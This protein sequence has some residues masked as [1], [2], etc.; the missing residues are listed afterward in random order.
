MSTPELTSGRD[1]TRSR[2]PG[3][4]GLRP[5]GG[6]V[7]TAGT[8]THA[9]T[10]RERNFGGSALR[11]D[12]SGCGTDRRTPIGALRCLGRRAPVRTPSC[13]SDRCGSTNRDFLVRGLGSG[14]VQ[15]SRSTASTA[16]PDQGR[17]YRRA[18]GVDV[19]DIDK[20]GTSGRAPGAWESRGALEPAACVDV[21]W[22]RPP[23]AHNA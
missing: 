23:C 4:T 17:E 22:L 7:M 21:R 6:G 3:A 2:E 19:I 9:T 20:R 10:R 14:R 1:T 16:G 18:G 12:T 8:T 5:A 13:V 15:L 11:G